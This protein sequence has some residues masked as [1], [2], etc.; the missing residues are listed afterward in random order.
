MIGLPFPKEISSEL[1]IKDLLFS[2]TYSPFELVTSIALFRLDFFLFIH[3][4]CICQIHQEC[5]QGKSPHH[6]ELTFY[7]LLN[8]QWIQNKSIE[9]IH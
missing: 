3:I 9:D 1:K 2:S 6:P 8:L 5:V 7:L 4:F